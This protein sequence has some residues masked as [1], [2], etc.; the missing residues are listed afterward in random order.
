[1]RIL[2]GGSL[3]HPT[4]GPQHKD[5]YA[6]KLL[7]NPTGAACENARQHSRLRHDARSW[8]HLG[9]QR[10]H[11]LWCP[12]T[13]TSKGPKLMAHFTLYTLDVG[14]EDIL[15]VYFGGSVDNKAFSS[16]ASFF[17]LGFTLPG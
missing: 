12:E 2:V 1:M 7:I 14:M 4:Y 10:C 15:S 13:W 11:A 16:L 6:T 17:R 8:W 5:T 3:L 9:L